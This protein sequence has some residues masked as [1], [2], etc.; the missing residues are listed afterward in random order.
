[1]HS[2]R[3]STV[4]KMKSRTRDESRNKK[5]DFVFVV[6]KNQHKSSFLFNE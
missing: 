2:T 5:W 1:V 3:N 4:K 6:R